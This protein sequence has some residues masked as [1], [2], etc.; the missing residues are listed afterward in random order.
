[1]GMGVVITPKFSTSKLLVSF[2]VACGG[3]SGHSPIIK[4][5]RNNAEIPELINDYPHSNSRFKDG[6]AGGSYS[7]YY[8]TPSV[9]FTFLDDNSGNG[10]IA[11]VP[12]VYALKQ[13]SYYSGYL[14]HINRA[15]G[16]SVWSQSVV[17]T[18]EVEEIY[19]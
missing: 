13:N 18:I 5:F 10:F 12:V 9:S 1:M 3:N 8:T 4:L 11:G 15:T 7:N 17:S 16:N 2:T 14:Y 6:T 19:Q